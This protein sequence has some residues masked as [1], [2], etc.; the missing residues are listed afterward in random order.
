M[1][2]K[3]IGIVGFWILRFANYNEHLKAIYA[4]DALDNLESI[5]HSES[6]LKF[7]YC[8][9]VSCPNTKQFKFNGCER[10]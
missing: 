1:W 7:L 5:K 10:S 9:Y 3:H 8:K 6:C 4:Y 2:K